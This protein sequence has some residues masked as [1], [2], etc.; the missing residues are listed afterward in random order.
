M[1]FASIL[2]GPAEERP[3]RKTTPPLRV[4]KVNEPL[5]IAPAPK[6]EKPKLSVSE[7][8]RQPVHLEP[9]YND[10]SP[11]PS[12][13]GVSTAKS[14]APSNSKS[15][16]SV[17]ERENEKIAKA[18]DRIDSMDKRDL[19][20]P[21]FEHEWARYSRKGKKRAR[22]VEAVEARKRRVC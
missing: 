13:N 7:R 8:R 19:E 15:R 22:E 10:I 3:P 5:A 1:S 9:S 2:S 21:G 14:A 16:K 18:M 6:V 20:A 11:R 4:N 17:S 12:T